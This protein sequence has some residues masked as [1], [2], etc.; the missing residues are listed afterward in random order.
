MALCRYR[1]D[2]ADDQPRELLDAACAAYFLDDDKAQSLPAQSSPR[3]NVPI[4]EVR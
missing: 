3:K 1:G 4:V 2:G